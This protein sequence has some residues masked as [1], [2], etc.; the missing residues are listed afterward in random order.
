[1]PIYCKDNRGGTIILTRDPKYNMGWNKLFNF[2]GEDLISSIL[3]KRTL[4]I[5]SWMSRK[6]IMIELTKRPK[7]NTIWMMF[8]RREL[9]A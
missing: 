7:Y 9:L 5:K 8:F 1:M 2:L 3:S 6:D 4:Y